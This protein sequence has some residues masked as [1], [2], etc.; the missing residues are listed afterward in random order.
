MDP[1]HSH[2]AYCEPVSSFG[3]EQSFVAR[4]VEASRTACENSR[5]SAVMIDRQPVKEPLRNSFLN[6]TRPPPTGTWSRCGHMKSLR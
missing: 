6:M 1:E 3:R 5:L 4:M 2:K